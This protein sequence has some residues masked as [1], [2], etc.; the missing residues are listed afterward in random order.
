MCN[1]I[2]KCCVIF[3]LNSAR[4]FFIYM[5]YLR[6][7]FL[8]IRIYGLPYLISALV[9]FFSILTKAA[10]YFVFFLGHSEVFKSKLVMDQGRTMSKTCIVM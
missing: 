2:V 8:I 10:V 6:H 5:P 7:I 3:D 4:M 1:I 9:T